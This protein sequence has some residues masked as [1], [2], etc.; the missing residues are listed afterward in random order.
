MWDEVLT[1]LCPSYCRFAPSKLAGLALRLPLLWNSCGR[2]V[3]SLR[4][5]ENQELRWITR[6]YVFR[7]RYTFKFT[8]VGC[9]YWEKGNCPFETELKRA[10]VSAPISNQKVKWAPRQPALT[11][12]R[13][14][15][16]LSLFGSSIYAFNACF[17]GDDS[18]LCWYCRWNAYGDLIHSAILRVVDNGMVSIL[19]F[20]FIFWY[21]EVVLGGLA[22]VLFHQDM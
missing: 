12:R 17:L 7:I 8:I 13:G 18:S 19:S 1:R 9:I 21:S 20:C 4:A 3:S 5:L 11:A 16:G 14:R 10:K 2:L 6:R 22:K 15:G